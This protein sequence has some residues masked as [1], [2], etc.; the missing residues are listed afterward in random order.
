MLITIVGAGYVGLSMAVLFAKQNAVIVVDKDSKKVDQIN[1]RISPLA[2]PDLASRIESGKLNLKAVSR[3]NDAA[4]DCDMFIIAVPTNYDEE[5]NSFDTSIIDEVLK[6]VVDNSINQT[7][8]I[9][10]TI[11][12]GY[13]EKICKQ[14]N[15]ERIVFSPEFMSEGKSYHDVTNPS[16]IIVGYAGRGKEACTRAEEYTYLY[17][18]NLKNKTSKILIMSSAEAEAVKLFSNTYLA[19]RVAFFNE[20]DS[21]AETSRLSSRRI[22]EGVCL[23]PR[24]GEGYANPS[25]GYGGYCLPKDSKQLSSQMKE[26]DS[27]II[28]AIPKANE[29]RIRF[30]A[31]QIRKKT[32]GT[33]GILGLAMKAGSDN[34]RASSSI[35]VGKELEKLGVKV[36]AYDPNV[37]EKASGLTMA[38][39]IEEFLE[40]ADLII[41]NRPG[42]ISL[43]PNNKTIYTRDIYG[44]G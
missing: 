38:S 16:R 32:D 29:A 8:V 17:Y 27:A 3:L 15:T 9:K 14:L 28:K 7:I 5:K 37:S 21:F 30:I 19:M 12:I 1:N 18:N 40:K 22:I 35:M 10:S 23:D 44:T 41:S 36:I 39:S 43:P 26:I 42:N 24:I 33:V 6:E 11:P 31:N 13:T 20:I 34:A 25:F 4:K 2:E